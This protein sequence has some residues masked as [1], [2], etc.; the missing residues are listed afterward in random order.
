MSDI[1][2]VEE[3]QPLRGSR[4]K[5]LRLFASVVSY[6]FHPVFMTTIMAIALYKLTPVSFAGV[7]A[8]S[9]TKWIVMIGLYTAV[10]SLILVGLLKALGFIKSIQMHD[11]KDRIIPLIGMMVFYWWVQHVF[12]NIGTPFILQVLLKGSF[13][14]LI[15]LFIANIFFKV[16]LHTAAAGGMIGILLVLMFTSP[17]NMAVPFFIA[18]VIAGIIG[19]ARMILG[20]HRIWEIWIGYFIGIAVQVAAYFYLV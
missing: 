17:V 6:I 11:A 18:L 4:S 10:Y 20:A 3:I 19:T 15:V 5:G 14:G 8:T 2:E 16:S 12:K 9:V 1:K 13:W 7:D